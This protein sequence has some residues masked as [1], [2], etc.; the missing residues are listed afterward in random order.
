MTALRHLRIVIHTR[1][2]GPP[3]FHVIAADID[4]TY[5]IADGSQLYGAISSKDDRLVQYWYASARPLLVKV[6][7]ETRPSDCPVGPI[8]V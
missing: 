1:E 5:S 2:H 6:W 8:E 7:N 3:H 4:A